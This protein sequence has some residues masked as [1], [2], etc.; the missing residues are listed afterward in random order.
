[1]NEATSQM[2]PVELAVLEFPA[3]DFDG[4]IAAALAEIVERDLVRV[5]DLVLL[6]KTMDGEVA[7]IELSDLEDDVAAQFDDVEGEV[8]WLLSDADV[9]GAA[10]RLESGTT[11][12]VILWENT[13]ARGFRKAVI[14]SGGRLVVHDQLDP[15]TVAAAVAETPEV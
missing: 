5:L 15:S 2:G 10:E 3:A 13:W 6:Q 7:V 12:L 9:R 4:S 11:G 1:M 14:N 8:M